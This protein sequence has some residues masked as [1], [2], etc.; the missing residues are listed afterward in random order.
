MNE[1]STAPDTPPPLPQ[2]QKPA[3]AGK[4][5][6]WIVAAAV[7]PGLAFAFVDKTSTEALGTLIFVGGLI[8]Q[9]VMSIILGIALSQRLG[10]GGGFAVLFVF[11]LLGASFVIGCCSVAAGCAVAGTKMNFH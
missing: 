9:L 7:L 6:L 8:G 3:I 11:L 10:K 2:V 5:I 1:P 4:W